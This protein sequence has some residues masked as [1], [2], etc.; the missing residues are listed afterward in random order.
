MSE[1]LSLLLKQLRLVSMRQN[2]EQ[3]AKEAEA[4][5]WSYLGY[6]AAL[7]EAEL[8]ARDSRRMQRYS[9]ASKLP[10]GKSLATFKF[11]VAK[12]VNQAQIQA[13]AEN[14]VWVKETENIV[15]FGPSGVGKTHLAAALG[16]AMIDHNVR[17]LFTQATALVQKLQLAK[18][19]YRLEEAIDK[20]SHY[21]LLILDD[22]GY[23]KKDEQESSVLFE[24][25]ADRYESGSIIITANQAFSEWDQ[26]FPNNV[27]AVAAIDRLV[28]H[29]TIINI[30]EASYRRTQASEKSTNK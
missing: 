8:A 18:K 24:L 30:N 23:V 6:L 13:L 19:E 15:I 29:S 17:V 12:S 27:M 14:S 5:H 26:I 28:H 16:Y 25:I 9:Q 10:A 1:A 22:L 2:F 20:L 7:C 3:F 21:Q 4:K 11:A